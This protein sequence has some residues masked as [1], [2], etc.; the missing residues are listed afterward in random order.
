MFS[1]I[2]HLEQNNIG[3][4]NWSL[5]YNFLFYTLVNHKSDFDFTK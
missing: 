1:Y 2:P 3:M 4:K 5:V